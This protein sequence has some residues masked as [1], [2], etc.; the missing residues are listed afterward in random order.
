MEFGAQIQVARI[1]SN[2]TKKEGQNCI[3]PTICKEKRKEK[4]TKTQSYSILAR[5]LGR[6]CIKPSKKE[7]HPMKT[8][9]QALAD[10]AR[11]EMRRLEDQLEA[12]RGTP[13]AD[14]LDRAVIEARLRTVQAE[15]V[16]NCQAARG[17]PVV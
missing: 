5:I 2:F 8:W 14:P 1:Y 16:V 3:K 4:R 7:R 17:V 9:A 11:M 10:G 6:N 15:Y 13:A 12:L